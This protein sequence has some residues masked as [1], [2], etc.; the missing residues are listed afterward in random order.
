M[1]VRRIPKSGSPDDVLKSVG[2]SPEHIAA[3]I[4]ELVG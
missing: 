4:K 2:L 3:K 1:T